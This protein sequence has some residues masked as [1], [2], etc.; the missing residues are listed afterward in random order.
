[1]KKLIIFS[2]FV[3]ISLAFWTPA[4]A[5]KE[6]GAL[7]APTNLAATVVNESLCITWDSVSNARKY[8][9]SV[10]VD[11]DSDGDNYNDKLVKFS[12]NTA[13]RNDGLDPSFPSLCVPLAELVRDINDDGVPEQ[14]FGTALVKVKALNP[15]KGSGRQ[16]H[17]FSDWV[18]SA[19]T[20]PDFLPPDPLFQ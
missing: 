8:A 18:E 19:M 16:N 11:V 10:N 2:L 17:A 1:M 15:G 9:V 4:M 13:D 6:L 12:F 20:A 5:K 14:I 7:P 3:Y